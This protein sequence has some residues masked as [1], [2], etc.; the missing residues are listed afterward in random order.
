MSSHLVVAGVAG[1][2]ELG[3]AHKRRVGLERILI[4]M[5]RKVVE[6]LPGEVVIGENFGGIDGV[7]RGVVLGV[8]LVVDDALRHRRRRVDRPAS[9]LGWIAA[10]AAV[11]ATSRISHD[12]G[13]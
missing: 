13:L 5:E 9:C 11:M 10:P 8:N 4:K 6:R 1:A 3:V 12:W 7:L 2:H